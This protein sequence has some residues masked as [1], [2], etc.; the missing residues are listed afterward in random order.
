MERWVGSWMDRWMMSGDAGWM[1]RWKGQRVGGMSQISVW[2]LTQSFGELLLLPCGF[3]LS[4][5]VL[6]M[7][8]FQ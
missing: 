4:K 2:V 3:I 1:D 8:P 5:L 6:S 7:L